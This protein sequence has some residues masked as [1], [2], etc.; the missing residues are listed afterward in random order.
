MK[1]AVLGAGEGGL[2]RCSFRAVA[3]GL[4]VDTDAGIDKGNEAL[5]L[6]TLRERLARAEIAG[7]E[8]RLS[9]QP[10]SG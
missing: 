5:E 3:H 8:E 9:V 4:P 10:F 7:S 6:V 1:P 2:H